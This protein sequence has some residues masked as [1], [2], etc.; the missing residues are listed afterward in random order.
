MFVKTFWARLAFAAAVVV[1][2]VA[3][4]NQPTTCELGHDVNTKVT[5][6]FHC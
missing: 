5:I 2:V 6:F 3:A 1:I 4:N